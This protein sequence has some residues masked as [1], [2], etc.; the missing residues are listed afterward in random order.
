MADPDPRHPYL[1]ATPRLLIAGS[2]CTALIAE[3]AGWINRRVETVELL[4]ADETRRKVSVD[5]TLSAEVWKR[6]EIEDGVVVPITVLTKERRRDFDLRDETG[7]AIPVLGKEQNGNLAHVAL[8]NA[9]FEALPDGLPGDAFESLTADLRRVVFDPPG[10]ARE[11]L[12]FFAGAAESGDP[13]RAAVWNDET[14]RRMLGALWENYVLFAVLQ[15]GGPSRRVLKY[16]YS[17]DFDA[18]RADRLR[19]LL[20]LREILAALRRPDRAGFLIATPGAGWT[21]SF[22][23]E[24]AMP[25][26]LRIDRAFLV[27]LD[28][29]VLVSGE[30]VDVNRASLYAPTAIPALADVNAYVEVA[31]ERRGATFQAA[32]TSTVVTGLL[33]LG[34]ASELDA[35]APGAAVSLLLAGAALFSGIAAVQREHRLVTMVFSTARR[36]L[37]IVTLCALAAS[38]TLAMEFPSRHPVEVWRWAAIVASLVALRLIWSAVRAPA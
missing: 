20:D 12:G 25:D 36:G 21:A 30:E 18:M 23:V 6:L 32:A 27:D 3:P 26:E 7:R 19:S 9:A 22:H 15:P 1:D 11:A 5:F 2:A 38:A 16:G 10:D 35:E 14:C 33:W 31:P 29:G 28:A 8:V 13:L 4:A 24:V 37:A 34:V 17:E